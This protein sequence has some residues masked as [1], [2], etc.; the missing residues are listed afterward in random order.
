M[1]G[2]RGWSGEGSPT[3]LV[4]VRHGVTGH[5]VD[6]RFSGGLGGSNPGLTDEGRAQVRATADWL[7]P[8]AEEIDVVVASPVRRTQESAEILARRLDRKLVTEDGLAEMEFG[9]WDGMTFAEIKDRYPD[10]LDAWLGSLEHTPGGGES[11]RVV[12][13]RVLAS[14]HRLLD[15]HAGR[16]VLAVSH[17]TPIKVL[18]ANAL[19]A[20]LE[21]VYRMEL[22]PASVTVLSYFADPS[23]GSGRRRKS[24]MRMFNG[25]P[26]DAAFTGR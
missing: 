2:F 16:T 4:L 24:S 26:T 25:R 5:T 3:T 20:P 11:F 13:Q 15:E 19:G 21:S 17:V 8:L 14:L 9:S 22:A 6:K 12:E 7:A 1:A 10:D 23:T 18:V